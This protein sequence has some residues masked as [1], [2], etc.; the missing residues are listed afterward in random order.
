MS[1]RERIARAFREAAQ[2]GHKAGELHV[3]RDVFDRLEEEVPAVERF[4]RREL[5]DRMHLCVGGFGDPIFY[6]A[7]LSPEA[8]EFRPEP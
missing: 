5:I 3:G 4:V 2:A 8:I 7:A 6:D 1:T